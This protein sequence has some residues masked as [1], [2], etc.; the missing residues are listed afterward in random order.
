MQKNTN[1]EMGPA[2]LLNPTC[3]MT[4]DFLK[5]LQN[6]LSVLHMAAQGGHVN[7]VQLLLENGFDVD[8]VTTVGL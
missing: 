8:D 7:V 1:P 6:G 4:I 5:F 2:N 3:V